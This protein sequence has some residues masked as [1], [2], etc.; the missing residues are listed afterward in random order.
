MKQS[1]V[2]ATVSERLAVPSRPPDADLMDHQDSVEWLAQHPGVLA[3][4]E[5]QWVALVGSTIVGHGPTMTDALRAA[6]DHGH[7]DPLLV[8]VPPPEIIFAD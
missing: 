3:G 8:P 1:L 4:Y 7:D 5:D 6:R 2:T